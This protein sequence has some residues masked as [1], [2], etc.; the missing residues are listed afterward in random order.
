MRFAERIGRNLNDGDVIELRSDIGGGK[1]TLVKGIVRGAGSMDDVSSPTF[2]V[3]NIYNCG[4]GRRINHYDFYRLADPGLMKIELGE[5]ITD[6][7]SIV[8]IEWA[9]LIKDVLPDDHIIIEITTTGETNRLFTVI[10][11]GKYSAHLIEVLN[12]S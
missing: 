2:T 3:S 7:G 12:N 8:L 4:D 6:P 1:T 5:S 11:T 9:G 10:A